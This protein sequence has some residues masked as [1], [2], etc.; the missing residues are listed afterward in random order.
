MA[1]KKEEEVN[2]ALLNVIAPVGLE[3]KTNQIILGENMGKAFGV[4]KYPPSPE[5]GWLGR[6]TNIPSSI[7]AM[8]YTPNNDGEIIDAINHNIKVDR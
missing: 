1:K 2:A 5:Y 4:I 3:C 6:I 8:T 7:V